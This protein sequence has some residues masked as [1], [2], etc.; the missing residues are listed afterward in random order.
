M[1]PDD[2]DCKPRQAVLFLLAFFTWLHL[3]LQ[4]STRAYNLRYAELMRTTDQ[5]QRM[6][7]RC[8]L[9]QKTGGAEGNAGGF[10][11]HVTGEL[12]CVL[13]VHWWWQN[14]EGTK[15][16]QGMLWATAYEQ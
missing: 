15:M 6:A 13:P 1:R 14:L 10:G 12:L 5:R 8:E 9:F 7:F 16:T 11:E 3:L 2:A 4:A